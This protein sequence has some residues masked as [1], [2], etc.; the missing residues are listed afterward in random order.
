MSKDILIFGKGFIGAR[1]KDFFG[2]V[3][4]DRKINNFSDAIKEVNKFQPRIII[5]CVGYTGK[6]N[7]DDCELDKDKTLFA[8]VYVPLILAEISL[9]RKIKFIHIGSDFMYHF[10]HKREP[11]T[12]E[13]EPDFFELYYSRT[14]IYIERALSSLSKKADI[15]IP[16]IRV[17]LDNRP[18]PKNILT[19]LLSFKK[20]VNVPN[21]ITYLPDFM[22]MLEHL[23]KVDAKGVFNTVNKG[24]LRYPDLLALYKKY[25]GISC[26]YQ[27]VRA[28]NLGKTRSNLI[29]SPRK[30]EKT[31]FKVKNIN[32]A[33]DE[34]M[35]EYIKEEKGLREKF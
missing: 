14:K 2:C 8:N 22:D 27:I 32:E 25:S 15:L 31:G 18:H 33:L 16:R 21:S 29:L 26:Q 6:N 7:V 35:R 23:I 30:L 34:C 1:I 10:D 9:R 5:N 24:T 13:D 4:T 20:I 19:K 3:V 28:E 11:L 12:E 17:P